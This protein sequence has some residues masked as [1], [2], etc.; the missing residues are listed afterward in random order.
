MTVLRIF[1]GSA[2]FDANVP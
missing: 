1:A 2:A